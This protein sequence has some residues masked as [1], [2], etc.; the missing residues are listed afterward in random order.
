MLASAEPEETAPHRTGV[1]AAGGLLVDL[2]Q[3]ARPKQWIKNVLVF[4]APGAAGVLG[5]ARPLERAAAAF[6]IFCAVSAGTY[7]F[8]D[9]LDAAADRQHPRKSRRPIAAGRVTVPAALAVG[10]L[11]TAAGI[12]ASAALSSQMVAV[13]GAYAAITIAYSLRLKH[14][15]VLDMGALASGFVLRAVAGGVATGVPL[16]NWFIIVA[17]FGSLFMVGGKRH[18]EHVE[19]GEARAGHRPIL[20]DYSLG[21]LR[22]V[23]S[24]SSA[25]AI[26][27]YCLWAFEKAAA[28]GAVALWFEL[29]IAPFVLAILRYALVIDTGGG[30]APEEVVLADR[31][32]QLL[33]LAWVLL[34][35]LGVYGV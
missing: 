27:G 22:Y 2:V 26:A 11:L 4:A 15:P 16:S 31:T 13:T 32:I 1:A 20:G 18:A 19:L 35:G 3:T 7:F 12:G 28:P 8:N 14:E 29:S 23:R 10:T 9:T 21:Y 33:G 17:S 5:H 30:G 24:V 25:V 6:A 34:F